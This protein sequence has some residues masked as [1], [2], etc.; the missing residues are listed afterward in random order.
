MI[1]ADGLAFH[2]SN[3]KRVTWHALLE[4]GLQSSSLKMCLLWHVTRNCSCLRALNTKKRY[5]VCVMYEQR[6]NKPKILHFKK[7]LGSVLCH[8]HK[9]LFCCLSTFPY[10]TNKRQVMADAFILWPWENHQKAQYAITGERYCFAT[11]I[12]WRSVTYD[13]SKCDNNGSLTRNMHA[14]PRITVFLQLVK[15]CQC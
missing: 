9:K 14:T 10:D 7:D 12:Y 3:Y 6:K 13:I 8:S 1:M 15:Y 11:G 5:Y 4:K 2:F